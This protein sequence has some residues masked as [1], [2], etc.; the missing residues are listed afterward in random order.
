VSS[1]GFLLRFFLGLAISLVVTAVALGFTADHSVRKSGVLAAG[2][3]SGSWASPAELVWLGR[4]GR[5]DLQLRRGLEAASAGPAHRGLEQSLGADGSCTAELE[6]S[7]GSPPTRRLRHAFATFFEACR[8]L[9]RFGDA[10]ETREANRAAQR[11]AELLSRADQALPPGEVR[12][13]P[14]IAGESGASRIEPRFARVAAELAGKPLQARC[15]SSR[16][17]VHLLQEERAYTNGQ[18][19]DGTLAFASI[20]GSSINL[21][22]GVCEAL[23]D[24]TYRHLRPAGEAS[25]LTLATAVVT[26]SHE[27]EHSRG[28]AAEAAAECYAIQLANRTA[29]ELGASADYA[30]A[31]VRTYWR[32]YA[33]E[34]PAYRSPDC[35]KGGALDLGHADSIWR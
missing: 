16:D 25:R 2:S 35:R 27:P 23:V 10:P 20:G 4:L 31:L 11:A 18:L 8:Y 29:V 33:D 34:L 30:T 32:H 12:G 21:G 13:L 1:E 28:I 7:V 15:W 26:L 6:R 14:V 19:G 22:P 17:W 24:L 9:Q 5:W 3:E